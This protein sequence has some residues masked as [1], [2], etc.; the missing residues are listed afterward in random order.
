M[1]EMMGRIKGG[2]VQLK[3]VN[4]VKIYRLVLGILSELMLFYSFSQR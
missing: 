4:S 1:A 2:N 3:K